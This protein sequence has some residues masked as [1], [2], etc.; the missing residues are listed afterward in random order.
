MTKSTYTSNG[1]AALKANFKADFVSGFSVS[2]IALPL[3][4][5]IAI[6][7]GFPPLAGLITAIVGG[8]FASRISGTY[9][10]I[11]G[12]AAGLIVI[13]LGA[14]ETLGGT[15]GYA[16]YPHALGA[17]LIGGIIMASFGFMKVGKLGDFFPLAAVHGM[18]ASIGVIIIIKQL[19]PAL[20]YVPEK[21]S[22]L[23]AAS[24][25]PQ[26][27]LNLDLHSSIIA[28]VALA[29]LI[30]HP[31]I[32]IKAIQTIPAPMW[33]LIATVP[34]AA[35]MNSDTVK[36]VVM[37][38]NLLG[39]GGITFPSFEK[40]GQS[41]FWVAVIGVALVSGIESLLS[42]KAV[43]NIDPLKRKSNLNEDLV[44]M[45]LGSSVAAAIGGLP[46]ISEIVRSSANISN[47]AKTQWANFAHGLFLL[48][49]LLVGVFLIEMIPLAALASMLV[50]TGFRLASP[51][52]FRHMYHIGWMALTVFV[53]TLFMVLLTDLIQGIAYG[54]LLNY[55]LIIIRGVGF[56]E[57]LKAKIEI[58]ESQ[59]LIMLVGGHTFS[60]YLSLKKQLAT[61]TDTWPKVTIDLAKIHLLDHTV[62]Q[63]LNRMALDAQEQRRTLEI[64]NLDTLRGDTPHAISDYSKK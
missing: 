34:L 56:G 9:V 53:A 38:K 21:G 42:A 6:A 12:P 31:K 62:L 8:L 52:E 14:I 35:Y 1:I 20:G 40:I 43:D 51:K 27:F 50:F 61:V 63:H 23:F 55:L 41:A 32:K 4:L 48:I 30:V 7:S 25:I 44:S 46:M 18:L 49:Y 22:I 33:V 60:N 2:L 36:M 29:I 24:Q 54:I 64:I 10:T 15:E 19:F 11:S 47:G 13:N 39:E 59:H 45:G 57:L 16:G 28:G 37:P 26:A 58:D 5:G 17:I 3:C